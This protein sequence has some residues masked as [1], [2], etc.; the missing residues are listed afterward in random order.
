M[1]N[2]VLCLILFSSIHLA[3]QQPFAEYGYKVKV[4]TLSNGKYEEFFDQDSI[5][6]IGS[7]LLNTRT[8]RVISFV[9]FDTVYSEAT[10]N[11]EVISRWLSPDPLSHKYYSLSP[12]NFVAN[13]PIKF[14]DPD[15]RKIIIFGERYGFLGLR[16]RRYEY[17]GGASAP[18]GSNQYTKDAFAALNYQRGGDKNGIIDQ[19]AESDDKNVFIKR[20]GKS[21]GFYNH[22]NSTVKWNNELG[23]NLLNDDAE[24]T[25][26]QP[27]SAILF[28]EVGHGYRH[29]FKTAEYFTDLA[30]ED[31]QYGNVEERR[32][33]EDYETPAATALGY[34]TRTNHNGSLFETDGPTSITP[35]TPRLD[36]GPPGKGSKPDYIGSAG[37]ANQP[38][39]KE[40]EYK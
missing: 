12:Y 5:V 27:A 31:S 33:I 18:D 35:K 28:H 30:T 3:A 40:D 25:G 16:R 6:Q 21:N 9:H 4:A 24:V 29:K 38:R 19:L 2:L 39:K 23:A 10:L 26:Q 32:V 14:V 37:P 22:N 34:G 8:G 20:T 1:K 7:V 15:G 36:I 11:P 13:N 17:H